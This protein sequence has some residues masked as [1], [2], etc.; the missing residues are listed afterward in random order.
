LAGIVVESGAVLILDREETL[1]RADANG[2]AV[3]G[4]AAE[5]ASLETA[6]AGPLRAHLIGRVRPSRRD[7]G[8]V[9]RGI[10]IV[11]RLAAFATAKAAVVARAHVLAV[12][13][14]EGTAAMLARVRGLRQWSDRRSRRR[15]GALVYR[16]A[17]G[18][19]QAL[20]T[21]L[22]QAA[23]QDLA[24]VAI[25]GSGPLLEDAGEAARL[26]D[27]LGLCLVTCETGLDGEGSGADDRYA[28]G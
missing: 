1:R 9:E 19:D 3:H 14:A 21:L 16:A 10:A 23:L 24:A 20:T 18:Q 5:A 22:Q 8:D 17:A 26:A 28:T 25:A 12:E 7:L 4:L 27:D 11:T 13:G 6:A 2:C 15:L